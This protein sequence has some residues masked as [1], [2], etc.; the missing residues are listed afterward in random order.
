MLQEYSVHFT[1]IYMLLIRLFNGTYDY[2]NFNVLKHYF[3]L[4]LL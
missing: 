3:S 2:V 4:N 1:I